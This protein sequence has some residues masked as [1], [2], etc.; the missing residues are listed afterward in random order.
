MPSPSASTTAGGTTA[1]P[2]SPGRSR[3]LL[4]LL[5]ALLLSALG[6]CSAFLASGITSSWFA[7][8]YFVLLLVSYG[9][10]ALTTVSSL[11]G[12]Y[13][14]SAPRS[15]APAARSPDQHAGRIRTAILLPVFNEPPEPI[16]AALRV[17]AESLD[18]TDDVAFFV[19]SDTQDAMRALHEA[20]FF[21]PSTTSRSGV[22]ITYRRRTPNTGRKAGNIAEFCREHGSDYEFAIVLDADS[23]MTADA[24]RALIG[25]LQRD[26]DAALIQSVS[27]P[28]SGTTLFARLQQFGAR[29]NTPLS[30]AG[31]N[32]WQHRRGTYW[33]HNAILRLRP[34]MEHATL[35][36]L[37]GRPPLGGEILCHDTIE[38]ALLLRA[39]WDVR[40]APDIAGS[41]ETTPSNLVDHLARERRWCQGNLQHLRLMLASGYR[42]ASQLHIAMGI[43]YYLAPPIGLLTTILLLLSAILAHGVTGSALSRLAVGCCLWL[44][45]FML[46][47]PRL[48][49]VARAL[50]LPGLARNGYGGRTRLIL[51]VLLEQIASTLL[52]PIFALSVSG[53]VIDTFRGKVVAW[54][55]AARGDRP[56]GWIEA[57]ERFRVHT[58]VGLAV[59][60]SL[61]M[62]RPALL[63]WSMPFL[64]G[65]I[66]SVP[67][68]CWSGSV[69]L[70]MLA[71]RFGLFLTC[72]ELAPVPEQLAFASLLPAAPEAVGYRR[73]PTRRD[74][75]T[76]ANGD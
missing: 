19:L 75:M 23:L 53:F 56:V 49:S 66:L 8:L 60:A 28:I 70:G 57:W 54:N 16:A 38:A 40:L 7:P 64:A 55:T 46:F 25:A 35:P 11:L 5:P 31:Q 42:P 37:P 51:G 62:I 21:M 67:I 43:L 72:D 39:G 22:P 32:L 44:T 63:P 76:V 47:A 52:A 45:L 74:D 24:I 20:R 15:P 59:M 41:F 17:M 58:L 48:A 27:Y 13:P 9:R 3:L 34:F 1:I 30:V 26:P 61:W 73:P 71:R 29:L 4:L 50:L 69:R 6:I 12:L 14:R 2:G 68:A 36:V 18:E 65:L 33:G 10:L